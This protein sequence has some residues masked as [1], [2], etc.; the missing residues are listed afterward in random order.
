MSSRQNYNRHRRSHSPQTSS[1]EEVDFQLALK[2]SAELNGDLGGH[3]E[4]IAAASK[5]LADN[6][7]DFE[8]ALRMQFNDEESQNAEQSPPYPR[9]GSASSAASRQTVTGDTEAVSSETEAPAGRKFETLSAFVTYLKASQC[10]NCS[11]R[12]F[13]CES[14]V[15]SLFKDWYE[16]KGTLSSLLT[17]KTCSNFSCIACS[18]PNPKRSTVL[19]GNKSVFWC[20]E[21][22][23]LI[24][25]W[26]LLCGFD[27]FYCW[28]KI[29]AANEADMAKAQSEPQPQPLPL[30]K[31]EGKGKGKAKLIQQSGVGYGGS[32]GYS[33]YM[34]S[35]G[36]DDFESDF[37]DDD[38]SKI[39]WSTSKLKSAIFRKTGPGRKPL[40]NRSQALTAQ[41]TFDKL[42]AIVLGL[43][44]YLLPSLDRS[45]HFDLDPP[46]T[47]TELLLESKVLDYCTELLRND[48]LDDAFARKSAYSALVDF[49]QTIG[50]HSTTAHLTV[51][52]GKPQEA[53]SCNLLTRSFCR[54]QARSTILA[55]AIAESL[56]DLS[57]LSDMLLKNA[58]HYEA[59][60]H[61]GG[62]Q[63]LLSLC[64][65]ISTLWKSLSVYILAP[66]LDVCS[67]DAPIVSTEKV[68]AISDFDDDHVC[69]T[70]AFAT[71]AKAQFRSGPRRFKRL[72]S[73][74]NVLKSSLPPGIF[75]RHG[76]SRLDMMKC[77]IVGPGDSP[78]EN[79]L[80]EFDFYCPVEYP[81]V[82]PM[83]SFKGTG[84]GVASINPNLYP[85]GKVCLSLLGTWSGEPWKPRESTLLQVL[86]SLQA[87]VFCEQP[88]YNE[89]GRE[90][91]HGVGYNNSASEAYNR[92]LR[93][94]TVRLAM[95]NW[96]E[97]PPQIWEDVVGQ[98]FRSNA[99]SILRTVIEWSKKSASSTLPS[100]FP[101]FLTKF[102]VSAPETGYG[103]ALPELHRH[104]LKYGAAVALPGFPKEDVES[105]SKKAR[106]KGTYP[107]NAHDTGSQPPSSQYSSF[108]GLDSN[109]S[110]FDD[111][112]AVD[113]CEI[114]LA[115]GIAS[116]HIAAQAARGGYRGF[117]LY[118]HGYGSG[119]RGQ[120]P[121]AGPD[122]LPSAS[123][124]GSD[125]GR[126]RGL[127]VSRGR[128]AAPA[129]RISPLHSFRESAHGT[130]HKLGDGDDTSSRGGRG[131]GGSSKS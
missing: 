42:G 93:E 88:W 48:S 44:H 7:A 19:V 54:A 124:S 80:F 37:D 62:D 58:E 22:G 23:R 71:M 43:L 38:L 30:P 64:R 110:N 131:G 119:G 121:G 18:T 117:S 34:S 97:K 126:G 92:K 104:L 67:A 73:E 24:L 100:I 127:S 111:H 32:E 4:A 122:V 91:S 20:C 40:D 77:I 49:V 10:S 13:K 115:P 79:G 50:M 60:Y 51:F 9:N 45:Y 41:Q 98:H 6:E 27:S 33:G 56:R 130:G 35:M 36:L 14:D 108:F 12:Y 46:A 76:E 66:N 86:V 17:C 85:D 101:N 102:G 63:E 105:K 129:D 72:I 94:L 70:H 118:Y 52:T 106:V 113:D 112:E 59:I 109:A 87:M 78:Y 65:R 31:P 53:E 3:A 123:P 47:V 68:A 5:R 107:E 55:P 128:G 125:R 74:I 28:T 84:G 99:D 26:L 61:A 75:V 95:L 16:G 1:F 103:A 57:K 25:I 83:V 90:R 114:P 21:D 8:F 120:V 82:P 29:E 39:Q 2:L 15:S 116:S 89:P 69:A 81:N 11:E 96:L